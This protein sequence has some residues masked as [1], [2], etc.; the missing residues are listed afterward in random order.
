[1]ALFASEYILLLFVKISHR[2]KKYDKI[3]NKIEITSGSTINTF[4]SEYVKV[5][6][7]INFGDKND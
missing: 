4:P 2:L 1:M 3:N 5:F 7:I 6:K